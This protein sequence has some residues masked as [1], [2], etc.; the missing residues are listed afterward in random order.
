[1]TTP[2]NPFTVAFRYRTATNPIQLAQCLGH[3]IIDESDSASFGMEYPRQ[4]L[5]DHFSPKQRNSLFDLDTARFYL[6]SYTDQQGIKYD[7]WT[8]VT[9]TEDFAKD[10]SLVMPG[11]H[12]H[13]YVLSKGSV[14]LAENTIKTCKTLRK[15]YRFIIRDVANMD[16]YQLNADF[17][18]DHILANYLYRAFDI[19]LSN[20][21]N[22]L[23]VSEFSGV[24]RSRSALF[25][26]FEEDFKY[27]STISRDDLNYAKVSGTFYRYSKG[28]SLIADSFKV[29]RADNHLLEIVKTESID[30]DRKIFDLS[31][32]DI[33]YIDTADI[34][35]AAI[36]GIGDALYTPRADVDDLD[37]IRSILDNI[38]IYP[39]TD[40]LI[41]D[42]VDETCIVGV[43]GLAITAS[44]KYSNHAYL[45]D[46]E[47]FGKVLQYV[48]CLDTIYNGPVSLVKMF[49][50]CLRAAM[51]LELN[52]AIYYINI[53]ST[54]VNNLGNSSAINHPLFKLNLKHIS[55]FD[56]LMD[57]NA[58][59]IDPGHISDVFGDDPDD[60]ILPDIMFNKNELI[61][62]TYTPWDIASQFFADLTSKIEGIDVKAGTEAENN[63]EYSEE[64]DDS[65]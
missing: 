32:A 45:Y 42:G 20:K 51:M 24:S 40:Y 28:Y 52:N 50:A 54:I 56:E 23:R 31:I 53:I 1:M 43:A 35:S 30:P 10:M 12:E 55:D 58:K 47:N 63:S 33:T 2:A 59:N 15:F 6:Y 4:L 60:L 38:F 13:L 11:A 14:D 48:K 18:A 29:R 39:R 64:A 46:K 17:I 7:I 5:I 57:N 36:D 62:D 25:D 37:R 65:I 26:F 27:C 49:F 9:L 8:C 41:Y 61:S 44:D 22:F 34:S 19:D 16:I 3:K 21:D